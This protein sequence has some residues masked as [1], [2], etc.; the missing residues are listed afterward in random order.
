LP[1]CCLL[2]L[3]GDMLCAAGGR[4]HP[5]FML[6]DPYAARV[7]PV[8]LPEAAYTG[9][10]RMAPAYDVNKPVL[11]GSLG[12]FTTSFQWQG[13]HRPVNAS[14]RRVKWPL[15]DVVMLELDVHTFTAV[16]A[17]VW[18]R[19]WGGAERDVLKHSR[20][21]ATCKRDAGRGLQGQ[22]GCVT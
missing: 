14:G 15:E 2:H 10:P 6:V 3:I 11:L 22:T 16:C 5:G 12:G 7:L 1:R 20:A 17:C 19:R 13:G 9:A 18:V 4:F 21:G 8:R